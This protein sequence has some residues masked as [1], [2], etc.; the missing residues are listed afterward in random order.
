MELEDL[1]QKLQLDVHRISV[2]ELC[3][4]FNSNLETGQG[5][6]ANFWLR[7]PT[8]FP[9]KY[10]MKGLSIIHIS[11]QGMTTQARKQSIWNILAYD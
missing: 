5:S 4:R 2:E 9:Q 3:Q 1:D 6:I 8:G 10:R 7:M 11:A